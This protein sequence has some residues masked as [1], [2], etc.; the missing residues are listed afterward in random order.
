MSGLGIGYSSPGGASVAITPASGPVGTVFSVNL[1]AGATCQ[2]TLNGSAISGATSSTYTSTAT[3]T[4]GC[5]V[6]LASGTVTVAA[7]TVVT[8]P[9][10]ST[11]SPTVGSAVTA[12]PG[13]YTGSPTVTEQWYYGDTGAAIGGATATTYTPVTADIGHT[14]KYIEEATNAAGAV[15]NAAPTTAAVVAAPTATVV[16]ASNRTRLNQGISTATGKTTDLWYYTRCT[17]YAV[18]AAANMQA[19]FW[20]GYFNTNL[21]ETAC[22]SYVTLRMSW[23]TN[24]VGTSNIVSGGSGPP[25]NQTGATVTT[26]TWAQLINATGVASDVSHIRD[27]NYNLQPYSA[28]TAAGGSVSTNV[29]ANDTVTIPGGWSVETDPGPSIATGGYYMT[30]VE[31][32]MP[33]GITGSGQVTFIGQTITNPLQ[34][35]DGTGTNSTGDYYSEKG[36]QFNLVTD[37]NWSTYGG[38]TAGLSAGIIPTWIRGTNAAGAKTIVIDGAS[39]DNGTYDYGDLNGTSGGMQKACIAAGYPV[40]NTGIPSSSL[41]LSKQYGGY[42]YRLGFAAY[43]TGAVITGADLNASGLGWPSA[44]T[45][46]AA[47]PNNTSAPSNL[48][49]GSRWWNNLLRTKLPSGGKIGQAT[50]LVGPLGGI[51]DTLSVT[52]LTASGTAA[53]STVTAVTASAHGFSVG[54]QVAHAGSTTSGYN[55]G[56]TSL[57]YFVTIASVPSSTSYTYVS[58][59][60]LG[61][62]TAAGTITVTDGYQSLALQ[63]QPT[64]SA[65]L[66]GGVVYLH[67]DYLMQRNSYAGQSSS[68]SAANGDSDF[69]VDMRHAA[70]QSEGSASPANLWMP[71]PTFKSATVDSGHPGYYTTGVIASALASQIASAVG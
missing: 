34:R 43:G 53:G 38:V 61:A 27:I 64:N 24:L 11:S 16:S 29:S 2:W 59:V 45:F 15:A 48:M 68:Y 5:V 70:G 28:F 40:F 57:P 20:N 22:P 65:W 56:T 49:A 66:P 8:A 52:S 25:Q 37:P 71:G 50:W 14:L 67:N 21:V 7:P 36:S 42:A 46:T 60:A 33:L 23:L 10:L 18:K 54:E 1:P 55:Q 13:T 69:A 35:Q 26:A 31:Q 47:A 58:S 63:E 4:L 51:V 12:T 17:H 32:H 6:T 19:G 41:Q 30:Q 9:T 62:T 39:I 44:G 3:G